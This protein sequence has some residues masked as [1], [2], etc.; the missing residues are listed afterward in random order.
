MQKITPRF[1]FLFDNLKKIAYIF[2]NPTHFGD[3]NQKMADFCSCER[4]I[5]RSVYFLY[6]RSTRG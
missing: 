1:E 5:K 2:V 4:S 3:V 6:I